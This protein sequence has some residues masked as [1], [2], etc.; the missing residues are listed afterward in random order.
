MFRIRYNCICLTKCS[1]N[2]CMN[3]LCSLFINNNAA[4]FYFNLR[5]QNNILFLV[6]QKNCRQWRHNSYSFDVHY[7]QFE[8]LQPL[9]LYCHGQKPYLWENI[10]SSKYSQIRLCLRAFH[11]FLRSKAKT[12]KMLLYEWFCLQPNV[13]ITHSSRSITQKAWF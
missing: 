2:N 10:I 11:L 5:S 6:S 1:A 3:I 9:T 7:K 13:T 8:N 12:V 4:V